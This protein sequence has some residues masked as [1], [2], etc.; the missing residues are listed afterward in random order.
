MFEHEQLIGEVV[1]MRK[2][3]TEVFIRATLFPDDYGYAAWRLIKNCEL[4]GLSIGIGYGRNQ[5]FI[6]E[7]DG[8]DYFTKM[9]IAEVSVCFNPANPD[10]HFR[11]S[12]S[13]AQKMINPTVTKMRE[14]LA[15]LNREYP[16]NRQPEKRLTKTNVIY[17]KLASADGLD[18]VLSD[19]T[20][21]RYGDIILAD[22]WDLTNFK[23][24]P[25]ALF[26]HRSDFPIGVWK[27]LR[28]SDG[29]LRG[30]LQ[31]APLGTSDRIDEVIRL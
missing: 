16:T 23:R 4:S 1:Y 10:C 11:V 22:G 3:E 29:A 9:K 12:P 15:R 27:N 26:S 5:F 20:P 18:F 13:G 19:A 17:K 21:D 31:L 8:I 28:A 24:N 7:K 2:T 14:T 30:T 25:I 6:F